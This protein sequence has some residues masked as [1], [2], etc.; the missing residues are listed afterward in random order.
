MRY[1]RFSIDPLRHSGK[2]AIIFAMP[3]P[4]RRKPEPL[5]KRRDRPLYHQLADVLRDEINAG[6]YQP[7]RNLPSEVD[8]GLRYGANRPTVRKAL[9]VIREEGLISTR[10]GERSMVRSTRPE[11]TV[12]LGSGDTLTCRIPSYPE[13]TRLGLDAGVVLLEVRHADGTLDQI[14]GTAVE[15]IRS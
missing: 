7:G 1:C 6:L 8:I 2:Y 11:H 5:N 13:R 10:R 14:A 9:A 15:V 12:A 4:H 3:M